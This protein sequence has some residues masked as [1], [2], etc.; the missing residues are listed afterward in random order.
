MENQSKTVSPDA[1]LAVAKD[2]FIQ[3]YPSRMPDNS[4]PQ[5]LTKHAG[6]DRSKES[7]YLASEFA[8]FFNYLAES[9]QKRDRL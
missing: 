6:Y 5:L 2:L 8:T 4:D 1:L 7:Q 3:V 9:M